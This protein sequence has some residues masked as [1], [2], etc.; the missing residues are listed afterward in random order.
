MKKQG[1]GKQKDWFGTVSKVAVILVLVL[2]VAGFTLNMGFFSIFETVKPGSY[3]IIDYTL[4]TEEGR[5]VI[6]SVQ[7]VVESGYDEGYTIGY[8]S[9][10]TLVANG[11]VENVTPVEV[12]YPMGTV[13]FALFAPEIETIG[14]EIMGMHPNEQKTIIFPFA[15]DLQSTLTPSQFEMIGGN[16]SEAAVGDWVP[17]GFAVA[18]IIPVGNET[19]EVPIRWAEVREK[20]EDGLLLGYGYPEVE[21]IVRDISD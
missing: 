17:L 21:V 13:Q 9:R 7:Q 10:L 1:K 8:T 11:T 4:R 20:G 5:P 6:S 16:F 19:P 18:P 14:E 12:Y 2:A 3:V 15:G